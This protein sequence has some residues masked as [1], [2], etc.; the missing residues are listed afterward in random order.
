MNTD[1]IKWAILKNA[2][3]EDTDLKGIILTAVVMANGRIDL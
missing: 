2:N 1:K 3:L